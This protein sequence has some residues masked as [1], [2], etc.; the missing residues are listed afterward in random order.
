M[1]TRFGRA[2]DSLASTTFRGRVTREDAVRRDRNGHDPSALVAL[3]ADVEKRG[4]KL[5]KMFE[6]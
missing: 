5:R 2:L 6:G 3:V 4:A 1:Q